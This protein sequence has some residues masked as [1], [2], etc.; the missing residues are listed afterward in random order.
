MEDA[1]RRLSGCTARG[2]IA[3]Y[4]RFVNICHAICA[5]VGSACLA[6]GCDVILL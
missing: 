4:A 5:S 3:P 1:K 6:T 2:C